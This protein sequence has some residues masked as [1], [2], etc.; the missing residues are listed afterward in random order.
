M[1]LMGRRGGTG[2][3]NQPISSRQALTAYSRAEAGTGR[4][5]SLT[6]LLRPHRSSSRSLSESQKITA[7][8]SREP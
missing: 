2:L 4:L 5:I 3:G 6:L 1:R 7:S 8:N